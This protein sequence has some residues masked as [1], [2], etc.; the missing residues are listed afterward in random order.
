M[1]QAILTRR[2]SQD[3]GTCGYLV[4]DRFSCF[5][6]EPPWRNNESAYSCIP[7]GEYLVR[8]HYSKRFRNCYWVRGTEPRTH[9]LIHAGNYAGDYKKGLKRHSLGC[10]L[11]GSK[12]AMIGGQY[13]VASSKTTLARM[14]VAVRDTFLLKIISEV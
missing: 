8:P 11:V 2:V 3:Y 10:L 14:R 7:P 1:E 13:G 5:T 9:I 6:L 4:F 12:F